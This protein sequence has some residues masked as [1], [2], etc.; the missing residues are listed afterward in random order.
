MNYPT[1]TTPE[2]K[3]RDVEAYNE[4]DA[5]HNELHTYDGLQPLD[6]EMEASVGIRDIPDRNMLTSREKAE[7]TRQRGL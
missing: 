2:E 6:R 7:Q 1:A 3:S 5:G 4:R